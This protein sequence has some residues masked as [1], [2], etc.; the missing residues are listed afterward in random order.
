MGIGA[1]SSAYTFA[2]SLPNLFR[3]LLG[4]G[5][6]SSAIVPIFSFVVKNNGTQSGFDFLN[7]A[8]SRAIVWLVIITV[9][10]CAIAGCSLAFFDETQ[11]RYVLGAQYTLVM[12]PYLILICVAA[13]FTAAL[14]VLDTFGIPSAT[15]MIL[16]AC[17]IVSLF[18]GI[19]FF[20][21]NIEMIA[22]SL[23]IGWLVGG[24]LQMIIPAVCLVKKGWKFK[25]DMSHS[26]EISELYTLFI[27]ALIGAAVVQL[28]IFVS[29][30]LAFNLNDTATP[31]LYISSRIMEFPLGVF[32]IA[33]ATVYFPRLAKLAA[34]KIENDFK[35]EY[36]EGLV[37]SMAIAIPAMFGIIALARDILSLLFK[38]GLFD[39]KDVDICLPVM[40]VSV[41]GLPFFAYTTYATRGF[42]SNKDTKTPV[43]ISYIAIALNLIL[44]F[45]LM[46]KFDASGLAAANVIAA[47]FTSV[48][49]HIKLSEKIG[50]QKIAL[51]IAKI[52]CAS[53]VMVVVCLLTRE[54]LANYFYDKTLV[55]LVCAI[56]IPIG[57][58]SYLAGLKLFRF[59]KLG[60]LKKLLKR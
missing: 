34:Q 10:G 18:C 9:V 44:S 7:K 36:T 22:F 3:R 27:P 35:K 15:P 60:E 39:M 30:L 38:W 24:F 21:S 42:H 41:A 1:V 13:I 32:S 5:A 57:A 53:L 26:A 50:E 56:V 25:F 20:G 43:K 11:T 49:L 40:I 51:D 6:L 37:I 14:N 46:F 33:I 17:I 55:F 59:S 4:E 29:K 28:N 45:A 23:C 16:N 48:A 52:V 58:L 12:F 19:F 31:A 47:I 2:F 8:I 54:L